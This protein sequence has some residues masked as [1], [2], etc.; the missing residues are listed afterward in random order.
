MYQYEYR[1]LN[2]D[3]V[4]QLSLLHPNK[5]TDEEFQTICE[6]C[7]LEA[8]HAYIDNSSDDRYDD[9]QLWM[10]YEH[11]VDY[12]FPYLNKRGFITPELTATYSIN[13]T[14]EGHKTIKNPELRH[15][16]NADT[17]EIKYKEPE[18]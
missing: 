8:T 18:C 4:I 17:R 12:I 9:D 15:Y 10:A 16:M 11:G 13:K 3:G 1:I 5:L 2:Y 7:A 14:W 6:E